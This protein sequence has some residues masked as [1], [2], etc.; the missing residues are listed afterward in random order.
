[1]LIAISSL[2]LTTGGR[3][4]QQ[5]INQEEADEDMTEKK[6]EDIIL[7]RETE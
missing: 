3:C 5:H 1:M 7:S 4:G 2:Q 6:G